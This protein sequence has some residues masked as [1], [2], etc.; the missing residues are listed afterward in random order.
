MGDSENHLTKKS[1]LKTNGST[2]ALVLALS[3]L[4]VPTSGAEDIV[5]KGS[6]AV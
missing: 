2:L 6:A 1:R 4:G 5:Y 3:A